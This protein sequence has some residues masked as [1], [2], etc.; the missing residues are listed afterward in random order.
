M[1]VVR[2]E[3]SEKLN[4]KIW[5]AHTQCRSGVFHGSPVEE[6]SPQSRKLIGESMR[7]SLIRGIDEENAYSHARIRDV[8]LKKN[9]S[10]HLIV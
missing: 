7:K 9:E 6:E 5:R 3:F 1:Q 4:G 8:A 2:I 10:R